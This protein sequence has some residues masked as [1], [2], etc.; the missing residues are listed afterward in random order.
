MFTRVCS[1]AAFV[2]EAIADGAMKH[3]LPTMFQQTVLLLISTNSIPVLV[4]II[5]PH[6]RSNSNN[7]IAILCTQIFEK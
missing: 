1:L 6:V 4:Y 2:D 5:S 7:N 3:V